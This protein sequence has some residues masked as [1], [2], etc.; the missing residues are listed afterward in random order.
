MDKTDNLLPNYLQTI[1]IKKVRENCKDR[2]IVQEKLDGSNVG[3][4]KI[5]NVL[6]PITRSGLLA[7]NSIYEQHWRFS[8]WVFENADRFSELLNNSERV[9]GEWL[10]QAHGTRYELSHEPFAVFDI[11]NF[12]ENRIN[13]SELKERTEKYDFTLPFCIHNEFKSLSIEDG[14]KLLGKYGKHGAIEPDE[15]EGLIYRIESD[16]K[17]NFLTKYV[18]PNKQ[19]GKYLNENPP[20]WNWRP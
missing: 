7:A 17:F 15:A 5:E 9:C 1:A 14:L 6:Y 19:N 11:I 2:V 16:D 8:N 10:M 13:Y 4:S 18:K 20:I 12:E 3:V